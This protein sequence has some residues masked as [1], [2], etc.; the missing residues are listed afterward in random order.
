MAKGSRLQRAVDYFREAPVDEAR[1]AF[2]LVQEVMHDR[3]GSEKKVKQVL[4]RRRRKS[5]KEETSETGAS[6]SKGTQ[7]Q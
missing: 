5:N 1:V 2:I 6:E 4:K 7:L 3:V